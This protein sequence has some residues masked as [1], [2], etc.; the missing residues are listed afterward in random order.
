MKR[1][2][3]RLLL[4]GLLAVLIFGGW[5]G[6]LLWMEISA[7]SREAH[8]PEGTLYAVCGDSQTEVGLLPELWPHFFNFSRSA[9]QLDQIELKALDLLERNPGALKALLIDVSPRKLAVQSIDRPLLLTRNAGKRFMLHVLH[10]SRSRRSLDGIV[11]LFRDAILVKRTTKALK[12]LRNGQPYESSIGGVG[13][14][15][16]NLTEEDVVRNRAKL[17]A[18]PAKVG[19]RDHR[20]LVLSAIDEHVAEL[21]SWGPFDRDS[22][23]VRCLRDIVALVKEHDVMP[24]LMMTPLSPAYLA[25]V[26]RE[27]LDNARSVM[28]EVAR[29]CG[30]PCLDYLELPFRTEEWRDGNHLNSHGAVRFTERVRGDVE[31]LVCGH[32]YEGKGALP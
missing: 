8:M 22:K 28:R 5:A 24:V 4:F 26:P 21:M 27:R 23:T 18:G 19:F 25:K 29:E 16:P 31:R 11:V 15:D 14:A 17:L 12:C 10:P 32:G 1:Y 6:L 20:D 30:V 9:I 13:G 2:V 7:Y 3:M